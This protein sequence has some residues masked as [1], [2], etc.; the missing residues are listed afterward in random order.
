MKQREEEMRSTNESTNSRVLYFSIFSML[1]LGMCFYSLTQITNLQYK[2]S[3]LKWTVLGKSGRSERIRLV[4]N[5]NPNKSV[6]QHGKFFISENSSNQRNLLNKKSTG[7]V[8][9]RYLTVR[10]SNLLLYL[11]C[12]RRPNIPIII[13]ESLLVQLFWI[14][15]IYVFVALL[16]VAIVLE[17]H[18]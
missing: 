11:W 9:H 5:K 7:Q 15:K 16:S 1:C 3:S 12:W 2:G 6:W 4:G 17:L 18:L 13:L 10:I 14:F 8:P